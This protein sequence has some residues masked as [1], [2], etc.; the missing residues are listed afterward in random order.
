MRSISM[1]RLN[2][3]QIIVTAGGEGVPYAGVHEFGATILPIPP[4][5]WLTIPLHSDYIGRRAFEFELQ[6]FKSK[7]SNAMAFLADKE[8]KLAYLLLKKVK[9]P[10]RPYL[11]PAAKE[12]GKDENIRK[13]LK[14]VYGQ[15]K[16][17]YEVTRV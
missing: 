13:R 1:A 7:K 11:Q 3:S 10:A 9:I 16:L 4:K 6:F 15:S 12:A 14:E 5:K 17:P 8:D 2:K